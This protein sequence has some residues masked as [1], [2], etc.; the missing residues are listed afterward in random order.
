MSVSHYGGN[1]CL[2]GRI[3][4]GLCLIYIIGRFPNIILMWK[5][6]ITTESS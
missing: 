1:Q 4:E 3:R 6:Q 5:T 2:E